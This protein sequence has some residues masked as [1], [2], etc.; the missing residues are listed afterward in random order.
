MR[1]AFWFVLQGFGPLKLQLQH[2]PTTQLALFETLIPCSPPLRLPPPPPLRHFAPLHTPAPPGQTTSAT[3]MPHH[4]TLR[5]ERLYGG[6][7]PIDCSLLATAIDH[8]QAKLRVSSF[9]TLM[10]AQA[11]MPVRLVGLGICSRRHCKPSPEEAIYSSKACCSRDVT[12][13]AAPSDAMWASFQRDSSV[14]R[15][16]RHRCGAALT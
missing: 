2:S 16:F 6:V 10:C 5:T 4:A 11:R 15:K 14:H 9:F 13:S 7:C 8:R 3:H 1:N 12:M